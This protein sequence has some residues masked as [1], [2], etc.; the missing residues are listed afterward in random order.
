[1]LSSFTVIVTSIFVPS[2]GRFLDMSPLSIA[3]FVFI[4]L[5]SSIGAIIIEISKYIKSRNE[6]IEAVN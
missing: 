4:I 5:I 6:V 1:M 2:I 3:E